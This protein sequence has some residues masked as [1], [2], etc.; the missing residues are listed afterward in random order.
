[1]VL[2]SSK[3]MEKFLPSTNISKNIFVSQDWFQFLVCEQG[4]D[5]H[6]LS[7]GDYYL[8]FIMI[9]KFG[10]RIGGA[11]L[12][13]WGTSR[14]SLFDKNGNE[15]ELNDSVEIDINIL[16]K[17]IDSFKLH[18]FE[19]SIFNLKQILGNKCRIIHRNTYLLDLRMRE[20]EAW[21]VIGAKT[22]NMVRKAIKSHVEIRFIENKSWLNSYWELLIKTYN[23]RNK[24]PPFPKRRLEILWDIL[25]PK[26]L[27]VLGAYFDNKLIAGAIFPY[28][29]HKIIYLSG[30]SLSEFNKYAPNNLLQWTTITYAI[31]RGI[32]LYDMYGGGKGSI[33]KFKASFGSS[34]HEFDHYVISNSFFTNILIKGYENCLNLRNRMRL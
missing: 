22:R 4:G 26:N 20:E 29:R 14:F 5:F 7:L 23:R 24:Q 13:G 19:F 25:H 30:A 21:E 1:M 9:K 15:V 28:N 33:G 2:K 27:L 12:R 16:K 6:V 32:P 18:Y 11:P 10:I 17:E 31:E 3:E 8:P 34:Y